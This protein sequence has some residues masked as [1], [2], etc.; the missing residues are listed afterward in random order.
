MNPQYDVIILGAGPAGLTAGLYSA[1]AK[2]N[3]LILGDQPGG[4]PIMYEHIGNYPGFPGGVAGAQLMMNM[5]MQVDQLGVDR[6][7]QNA[8][9]ISVEDIGI[10]VF[11]DDE[12]YIGKT[13]IVATGSRPISLDVP[14]E[15]ELQ[16]IFYCA[17]C[18][19]PV[20]KAMEKS[21]A[22]VVGGGNSALYTA[23]YI[24]RF[25]EEITVVHRGAAL[26]ADRRVQESALSNPKIRLQLNKVVKGIRGEGGLVKA[27]ILQDKESGDEAE[28]ETEGIFVGIGQRPNSYL[29]EGIVDLDS[30]GFILANRQME[31]SREGIYAAGDVVQKPLRQ[32]VTAVGDG[33]VA[34]DSAIH[35]IEGQSG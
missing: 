5:V 20:F 32:I 15:E 3:T 25:A 28:L 12:A 9:S 19:A 16:G 31:T 6:I 13:L 23:M 33:A 8:T 27:M 2:L 35:Y 29:V 11:T 1:R 17:H 34:A 18:D 21:R 30:D 14:G 4:N 24:S 26:R 22:S 10:Q 7:V